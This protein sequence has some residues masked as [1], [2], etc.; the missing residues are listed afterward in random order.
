MYDFPGLIS[1]FSQLLPA[2]NTFTLADDF[3]LTRVVYIVS[4]GEILHNLSTFGLI[5]VDA[6]TGQ[7]PKADEHLRHLLR[8]CF[9]DKEREEAVIT[10]DGGDA[11]CALAQMQQ[12]SK[13]CVSLFPS[14]EM[15]LRY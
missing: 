1:E 5:D 13:H 10:L 4:D 3:D 7:F 12:V 2:D 9:T 8:S 11:Q 14:L 15:R 6:R